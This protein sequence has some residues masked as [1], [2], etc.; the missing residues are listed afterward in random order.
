VARDYSAKIRA[1]EY[2][3]KIVDR[4][5]KLAGADMPVQH[6]VTVA[7]NQAAQEQAEK[8]TGQFST[9]RAVS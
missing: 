2:W 5:S 7:A 4:L 6:E 9:L 1:G 8:V 3:L